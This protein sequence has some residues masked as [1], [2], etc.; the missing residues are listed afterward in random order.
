V[1]NG[2]G[3]GRAADLWSLGV[4]LFEMLVGYTPF[5]GDDINDKMAIT[6]RILG[7]E[8]EWPK[9]M[10]GSYGSEGNSTQAALREE[11]TDGGLCAVASDKEN[12]VVHNSKIDQRM[13]DL[14]TRLL[15][16]DPLQRL[17]C[18]VPPS[19]TYVHVKQASKGEA[20][21][22][23]RYYLHDIMQHPV[24][25]GEGREGEGYLGNKNNSS[26]SE[27]SRS[28]HNH[29]FDWGAMRSFAMPAPW[30]PKLPDGA[31]D[32]SNFDDIYDD[33]EEEIVPFDGLES[34]DDF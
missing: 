28:C 17:G 2:L 14:V 34:F 20:S 25:T 18:T 11:A 33:D 3:H 10:M 31:F 6:R 12:I 22:E 1:L 30:V 4:V 19:I 26:S 7:G 29:T 32:V 5:V 13:I 27:M 16:L 15:A 9:D 24:Y 8:L 21:Y 23:E